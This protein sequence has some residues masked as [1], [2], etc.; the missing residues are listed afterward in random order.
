MKTK[1]TRH[2]LPTL[3]LLCFCNLS[4][5]QIL[6]R[7]GF[8]D[9]KIPNQPTGWVIANT[10]NANWQSL[11]AIGYD[12]NEYA[13][14][15]CMFLDKSYYGDQSD[16][17]LISPAFTMEAGK[18]YSISFYY[19]NQSYFGNRLQITLGT[20]TTVASQTEIIND[21]KFAT[22]YYSKAQIN[23]TAT[24]TGVKYLG[25]HAVTPKTYTYMY[26]DN[27][28]ITAVE[29]FEPLNVKVSKVTE[30]TAK[31]AWATNDDAPYYEYGLSDTLVP[32]T[33]ANRS[34]TGKTSINLKSLTA[35]KHYYLF[36]RSLCSQT[37]HSDWAV[38]EFSTS[39]DAT[40]F[41]T[42]PCG[43]K[44]SNEFAA[45]PGLYLDVFCSEPYF[46]PEFFHK[47]IPAD[48]GVYT[49]HVYSVN[50]GQSM[51]FAYKDAALGAGPTGWTC[52]G[53]ANDFGGK[54][55][56]GPLT[57]GKEY[58]IM[59]KA[60]AS[61]GWLS[62]YQYGIDCLSPKPAAIN[63]GENNAVNSS[64]KNKI[65]V[66]PNPFNDRFTITA[67]E[68][69]ACKYHITITGSDGRLFSSFTKDVAAGY[70]QISV[71]AGN[72]Q[73]GIYILKIEKPS[74]TVY[75]KIVKQ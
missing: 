4:F 18:K 44:F 12:G 54:F 9:A 39:F 10:G 74:G 37:V 55:K 13:G 42:L 22:D 67:T 21:I 45:V 6:L 59:E 40:T 15:K 63:A 16:A 27:V 60:K 23:Y 8:E 32:P 36:V 5:S 2:Y 72:L 70:N 28:G 64:T 1:F 14:N 46:G 19:K 50:T 38:E 58:I 71:N 48:S 29:C 68:T 65:S 52:I 53:S 26:L 49:L 25:F 75:Q 7:S 34:K 35:A 43:K 33:A 20:D 31:A 62:S 69:N 61:P 57:A 11:S 51:E 3:F 66:A 47:F 56:F 24:E 73:Q 17:W 30:T 41:D